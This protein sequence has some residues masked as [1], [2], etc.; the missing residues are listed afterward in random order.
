MSNADFLS[1]DQAAERLGYSPDKVI[2]ILEFGAMHGE[3]T[4]DGDWLVPVAQVERF[5]R[6]RALVFALQAKHAGENAAD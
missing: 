3:R 4:P 5:E 6:Q 2:S 1:L